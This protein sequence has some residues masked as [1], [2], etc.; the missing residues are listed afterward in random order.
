VGLVGNTFK[1][2]VTASPERGK[3]NAAVESV[4]SH[5]LGIPTGWVRVVAGKTSSRKVIEV[6]GLDESEVRL[7]LERTL[8]K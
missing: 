8:G 1:V 2:C 3:A 7:R 6:L 5:A 4:L